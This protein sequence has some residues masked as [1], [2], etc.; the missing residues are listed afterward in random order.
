MSPQCV[1]P[2]REPI[3]V[4]LD[5]PSPEPGTSDAQTDGFHSTE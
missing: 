5:I 2:Y 4:N 3:V 1:R